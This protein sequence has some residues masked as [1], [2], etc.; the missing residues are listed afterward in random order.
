MTVRRILVTITAAIWCTFTAWSQECTGPLTVDL[1]GSADGQPVVVSASIAGADQEICSSLMTTITGN[2]PTVGTGHWELISG[3]G[4]ITFASN[5]SASTAVTASAYGSYTLSWVIAQG[6]CEN[7]DYIVLHFYQDVNPANAGPDKDVCELMMTSLEGNNPAPNSGYW[8]QISGPSILLFS[9][10]ADPNATITASSFGLY[11]LSWNTA[12]GPCISTDTVVI[13]FCTPALALS[14]QVL[15]GS[16]YSDPGDI[17]TYQY[18]LTNAGK[19]TLY[20]PFNLFDDILGNIPVITSSL[21]PGQSVSVTA[22]YTVLFQD[23]ENGS[24]TSNVFAT[25]VYNGM[26]YT[27]PVV[28]T[29]ALANSADLAISL[30]ASNPAPNIGEILTFTTQLT[31]NGPFDATGVS[32]EVIV[33]NGFDNITNISNGGVYTST[34]G[35]IR[36]TGSRGAVVKSGSVIWTNLTIPVGTTL[37]LSFDA[38]VLPPGPGVS[39]ANCAAVAASDQ[40]DPTSTPGDDNIGED[41]ADEFIVNPPVSDISCSIRQIDGTILPLQNLPSSALM[42]SSVEPSAILAGQTIY[43]QLEAINLGPDTS[44]QIQI[45]TAIPATFEQR[46]FSVD[47][48]NTWYPW[49]SNNVL[50]LADL[51]ASPGRFTAIAR[52]KVPSASLT[53]NFDVL[54]TIASLVTFDSNL[55]NNVIS[56][57]TQ[58]TQEADVSLS[59][60]QIRPALRPGDTIEY[61]ILLVNLGP[62]DAQNVVLTDIIN[63][64]IISGA[65]WSLNTGSFSSAWTGTANLGTLKQNQQATVRIKGILVNSSPLPNLNPVTNTASVTTATNEYALTNNTATIQS[66]LS[67]EADLRILASAPAAIKAGE[68]LE[69]TVNVTNLS[70]TFQASQIVV[71]DNMQAALFESR[72]VSYDQKQTWQPWTNTTTVFSLQPLENRTLYIRGKSK[73][74]LTAGPVANTFTV[75]SSTQDIAMLNNAASV[76]TAVSVAADIQIVKTLAS[77][78]ENVLPGRPIEYLLTFTNIGPSNAANVS[79]ADMIPGAITGPVTYSYCGATFLPWTGSLSV[80]NLLPGEGCTITIRGTIASGFSGTQIVNTASINGST[81]DPVTSNNTSVH[82]A[83]MGKPAMTLDKFADKKVNVK[84]GE[85][86]KYSYKVVNTGNVPLTNVRI[87]DVHNG[88]GTLS[89]I[90][91]AAVTSLAAGAEVIFTSTYVVTLADINRKTN[92]L[93][94]ATALAAF[95]N[96]NLSVTDSESVDVEELVS[97]GDAVWHDLNGDGQQNANE[98]GLAGVQVN[99]FKSTG[100]YVASKTTNAQGKYLFENMSHGDYYIQVLPPSG[101]QST[102]ADLGNDVSDSDLGAFNGPNT[103]AIFSVPSGGS[104]IS[105]D[106]GFYKCA[107]IGD[108]VWLDANRNDVWNVN[109]AGI[110]GIEVKLWRKNQNSWQLLRTQRTARKSGTGGTDGHFL[111]CEAPGQYYLEVVMPPRG[112]VRARPDI[113]NNEEIDSDITN[114]NGLSTTSSFMVSSGQVKTDL[115]AGFYP[116]G[117]AGNL[118]WRDDNLNGV[119][120]AGE[121]RVAGVKVEAVYVSTGEVAGF[122]HTD[123]NGLFQLE[124]L[125]KQDYYLRFYPPSGF[126]ATLPGMGIDSVDSDVDHSFGLNTTRAVSILPETANLGVDMGLVYGVLP[127][128]WLDVNAFR[129]NG[130]HVVTWITARESNVSHYEVERKLEGDQSFIQVGRNV[131]AGGNSSQPKTYS[132]TDEDVESPGIYIYRVKQVDFDGQYSYSRLVKVSHSGNVLTDMYPNPTRDNINI[133]VTLPF[134][135]EVTIELFDANLSLVRVLKSRDLVMEG[136]YLWKYS[137]DDIVPGAYTVVIRIDDQVV[138]KKLIR[139]Q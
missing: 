122:T 48:G 63:P 117:V 1:Q 93:N 114:S 10:I 102:F 5:T 76:S 8:I 104:R 99:L 44:K 133:D 67:V 28:Q 61:Q 31:N 41:D 73:S 68:V 95:G 82:T 101:F 96:A 49:P 19:F 88:L 112:L 35:L 113:G 47:F 3:P 70:N 105:V 36:I 26:Q 106:V 131:Q 11:T 139:L 134:D 119:Q 137:L 129:E 85:T 38:V 4:N 110:N 14:A 123:E 32:V 97:I 109:E 77:P 46:E 23:F 12:F 89:A 34:G 94:T 16:P 20:G 33:A 124:Y 90:S 72:E 75:S 91:P 53:S 65:R 22:T 2:V 71:T 37:Y 50:T 40:Y 42:L 111:F 135:A 125:E 62:S 60:Q 59:L 138:Q 81:P 84:L 115:G 27:S 30:G 6:T 17:V 13:D 130:T 64:A 21:A 78:Q 25:T 92:I 126:V 18:T 132:L 15:S 29:V 66:Q 118:V 24:V 107:Q 57:S 121:Q 128:E 39:Y 52:A 103:T 120:E 9:D 100:V 51:P 98:P 80:G 54:M 45:N 43:W 56:S 86:I 116:M 83:F 136:N 55:A 79:I 127:V 58:I 7:E 74:S 69:Y 108:L 87:T